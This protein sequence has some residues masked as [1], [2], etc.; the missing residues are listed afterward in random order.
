[1]IQAPFLSCKILRRVGHCL[2]LLSPFPFS[3]DLESSGVKEQGEGQGWVPFSCVW[4]S[5]WVIPVTMTPTHHQHCLRSLSVSSGE[6]E[7]W[8]LGLPCGGGVLGKSILDLPLATLSRSLTK[9]HPCSLWGWSALLCCLQNGYTWLLFPKVHLTH[10]NLMQ[11][12]FL[13]TLSP[14]ELFHNHIPSLFPSS[15]L[16]LRSKSVHTYLQSCSEQHSPF[17]LTE[18]LEAESHWAVGRIVLPVPPSWG[19]EGENSMK[20]SPWPI[21]RMSDMLSVVLPPVLMFQHIL[22]HVLSCTFQSRT[23]H[24]LCRLMGQLLWGAGC[25]VDEM[26]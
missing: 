7:L 3:P 8:V 24:R 12:L 18:S 10:K 14:S 1:M 25:R 23:L 4:P 20:L 13:V 17:R 11:Q 26:T 19:S 22:S 6:G 5:L 2:F 9:Q 16:I 21:T 15:L